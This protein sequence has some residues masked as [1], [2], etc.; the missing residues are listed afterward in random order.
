M[1]VSASA[2]LHREICEYWHGRF[3]VPFAALSPYRFV[4]RAKTVWAITDVPGL[5]EVLARLKV[6]VAGLPFLRRRGHG[7]KPTT[8]ALLLLHEEVVANVVDLPPGRLDPFLRGEVLP[9]PFDVAGGYVAVRYEGEVLGCALHG[10]AGLRSQLP[11]AWVDTL[12]G[13]PGDRDEEP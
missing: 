11:R 2:S 3:G 4:M 12:M 8:A 7:W 5:D 1:L 9:G 6:E 10:A 13:R